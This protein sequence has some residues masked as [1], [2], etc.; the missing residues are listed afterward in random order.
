M[1]SDIKPTK[2]LLDFSKKDMI[3]NSEGNEK[4][5]MNLPYKLCAIKGKKLKFLEFWLFNENTNKL[6]RRRKECPQGKNFNK[7]FK[8]KS[9][10]IND[11]LRDGYRIMLKV[12]LK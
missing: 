5:F 12:V 2:F 6:H 10:Y 3:V 9:S 11:A 7:W 1:K 8:E 4:N